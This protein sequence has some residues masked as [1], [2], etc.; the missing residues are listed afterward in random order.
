MASEE[1][2]EAAGMGRPNESPPINSVQETF[3]CVVA[4]FSVF[5][6]FLIFMSLDGPPI[7]QCTP[8]LKPST[9]T[10]DRSTRESFSCTGRN[11]IMDH[12][13]LKKNPEI[14]YS[15]IREQSE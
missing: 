2:T 13:N 14:L 12:K 8:S 10:S 11:S 3:L 6:S 7:E 15:K 1:E 4:H 5:V 9:I